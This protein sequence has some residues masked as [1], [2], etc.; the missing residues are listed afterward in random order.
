MK[1][2]K[3][4]STRAVYKYSRQSGLSLIELMISIAL[5]IFLSWGAMEAFISGKQA[6]SLQQN[7]SRMQ[8]NGRLAQEF[9]G[10]EIRAAGDYGCGSGDSFVLDETTI[11][12][13]PDATTA[14]CAGQPER[15]NMLDDADDVMNDFNRVVFGY[16]DITANPIAALDP[17]PLAGTDVLVLRLSTEVGV[18]S[19]QV[20]LSPVPTSIS[21][22]G[23]LP[24]SGFISIGDCAA[25]R[26]YELTSNTGSLASLDSGC[27]QAG[28]FLAVGA[29]VKQLDTVV[30][31]VGIDSTNGDVP[32]LYRYSAIEAAAS[33]E[34]SEALLPGVE[35]L[36][37]EFGIDNNAD[38][39]IDSYASAGSITAAQWSGWDGDT[40]LVRAVRYALLVRS[41]DS[42][43]SEEQTLIYPPFDT[44]NSQTMEDKRLRMV[45][46]GASGVRSRVNTF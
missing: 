40:N 34:S 12:G 43:L 39:N 38:N 6:Y 24:A 2:S 21:V 15:I 7:T 33:G 41:D 22:N 25:L 27:A 42:L 4:V 10:N 11:A 31:Y 13:T 3:P 36:Q 32:T 20:N 5:G 44:D 37:I 18:L 28:T 35:D 45:F 9:I 30:Y 1:A 23:T 14:S 8:E 19:N 26:I 17:E 46:M 16:N 29:T